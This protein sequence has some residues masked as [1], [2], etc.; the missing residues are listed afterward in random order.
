MESY[1]LYEFLISNFVKCLCKNSDRNIVVSLPHHR[2]FCMMLKAA[3]DKPQCSCGPFVYRVLNSPSEARRSAASASSAFPAS[4][5]HD[6]TCEGRGWRK[7]AHSRGL[8][9]GR[10]QLEEPTSLAQRDAVGTA[11]E[12]GSHPSGPAPLK[13]CDRITVN[14][15]LAAL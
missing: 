13:P 3:G 4:R 15:S 6:A 2:S 7:G 14:F 1:I 11:L 10:R 5:A 8:C 9:L 12:K